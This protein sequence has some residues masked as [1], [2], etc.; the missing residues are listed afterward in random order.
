MSTEPPSAPIKTEVKTEPEAVTSEPP[1]PPRR[2]FEE[3]EPSTS[4]LKQEPK[5]AATSE[6]AKPPSMTCDPVELPT[7]VE[8]LASLVAANGDGLE[9][10]VRE[11]NKAQEA[12][13]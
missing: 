1:P 12:M 9:A 8:E 4:S 5:E 6:E 11:R 13:R 3:G 2:R 7:F 10:L